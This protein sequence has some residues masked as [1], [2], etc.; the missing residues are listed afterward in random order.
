MTR[1]EIFFKHVTSYDL[2]TRLQCKNSF[3]LPILNSISIHISSMTAN[4]RKLMGFFVLLEL[5][6]GQQ[7]RL[8]LSKKNKIQFKIKKGM[9]VGC[10]VN[11]TR[12]LS[13]A[14]LETL[15]TL[16]FPTIKDFTGFQSNEKTSDLSFRLTQV[17][18]F[19]ELS[20]EFDL[21]PTF[22]PVYVTLKFKT[23]TSYGRDLLL[24][25]LNFPLV[26]VCGN[27][28]MVE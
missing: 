6:S 11:L 21:I 17:L 3:Q 25:A 27:N 19:P 20:K 23:P 26:K 10:K 2:T 15:N 13:Y 14:F 9:L 7:G 8:T 16:I 4:K 18:S 5:L 1:Y 12:S 24:T 22:L 28:S